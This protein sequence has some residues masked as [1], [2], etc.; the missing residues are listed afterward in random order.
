MS[1]AIATLLAACGG[2]Q[3]PVGAPGAM[4]MHAPFG[5]AGNLRSLASRNADGAKYPKAPLIKVG[6]ILHGTTNNGGTFRNP[7]TCQFGCGTVFTITT[8]GVIKVLHSFGGAGDGKY[9][10]YAG[11]LNVKGTLYGTT[12]A[13]GA[14]G[15]GTV[16]SI[17]TD[18]VENVLHSF[19]GTGDGADPMGGTLIKVGAKLYGTTWSGG[20]YGSS[21]SG[22]RI[23]PHISAA[24]GCGTVF[25]ITTSGTE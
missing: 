6:S 16:F 13:G 8:S 17:T 14:Y 11:L 2:S 20:A 3:L 18:G 25:S 21:D 19:G 1:V 23:C 24:P 7:K 10:A 22:S 4:A 12:S 9:P 15:A 5:D